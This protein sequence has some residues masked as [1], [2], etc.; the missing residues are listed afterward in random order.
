MAQFKYQIKF[1]ASSEIHLG[2]QKN[3]GNEKNEGIIAIII[4]NTADEILPQADKVTFTYYL[5][6]NRSENY[7]ILYFP[8]LAPK[9]EYTIY[10]PKKFKDNQELI[11]LE[12]KI[13]K[14]ENI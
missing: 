5:Q 4:W 2:M 13:S 1:S 11:S 6:N 12:V 10:C 8:Q 14:G 3:T 7:E 9:E